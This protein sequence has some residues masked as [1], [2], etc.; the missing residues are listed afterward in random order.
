MARSPMGAGGASNKR[1]ANGDGLFFS[2]LG[3]VR[4]LGARTVPLRGDGCD[5]LSLFH[6]SMI[7]RIFIA[8]T[9]IIV[10]V[11]VHSKVWW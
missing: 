9:V 3:R 4:T 8:V 11:I 5:I 10:V 7:I 6:P 1:V 2:S